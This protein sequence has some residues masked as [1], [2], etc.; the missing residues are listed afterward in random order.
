MS[1]CKESTN[2]TPASDVSSLVLV[3]STSRKFTSKIVLIGESA[4][5]KSSL[6][7]RMVYGSFQQDGCVATVGLAYETIPLGSNGHKLQFWDTA[8]Q[9][10]YNAI[11]PAFMRNSQVIVVVF[12]IVDLLSY[13]KVPMW[14]QSAR[15]SSPNATLILVGN[16]VDAIDN[17]SDII[18]D[19]AVEID[20]PKYKYIKTSARSGEGTD[21]LLDHIKFLADSM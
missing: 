19:T 17:S 5:G 11:V 18:T 7:I 4:V 14:I 21:L 3:P 20:Y 2:L 15:E 9:E 8:G 16:K 6:L 1:C 10:A 12:S 13:Y